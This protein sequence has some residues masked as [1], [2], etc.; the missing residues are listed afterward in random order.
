[1]MSHFDLPLRNRKDLARA[2][3]LRSMALARPIL[4][5]TAYENDTYAPPSR[6]IKPTRNIMTTNLPKTPTTSTPS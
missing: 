1:M 6:H 3:Q 2:V 4:P 5:S